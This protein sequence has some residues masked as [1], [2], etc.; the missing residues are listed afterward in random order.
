[1]NAL[2]RFFENKTPFCGL[3]PPSSGPLARTSSK[4][5]S[6]QN[7]AKNSHRNTK[8]VYVA[9]SPTTRIAWC[10][11]SRIATRLSRVTRYR[12]VLKTSGVGQSKVP[13]HGYHR[14][15]EGHRSKR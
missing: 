1:M 4:S 13:S 9:Y 6:S 12:D 2:A 5:L 7:T 10:S 15:V 11:R 14:E 3:S 8:A